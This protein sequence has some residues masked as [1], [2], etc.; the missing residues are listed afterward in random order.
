VNLSVRF[1]RTQR[2]VRPADAGLIIALVRLAVCSGRGRLISGISGISGIDQVRLGFSLSSARYH[3]FLG[4]IRLRAS[5]PPDVLFAAGA[6]ARVL[7]EWLRA[8][9]VGGG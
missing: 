8:P 4:W 2:S 9:V 5:I 7:S 6:R 3:A 1:C